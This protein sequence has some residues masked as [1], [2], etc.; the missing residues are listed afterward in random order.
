MMPPPKLNNYPIMGGYFTNDSA[1]FHWL[2]IRCKKMIS[3]DVDVHH[4]QHVV[5][6]PDIC[7]NLPDAIHI[8]LILWIKTCS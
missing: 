2:D 3:L 5:S 1:L 6:S 8:W 7:Q 4:P